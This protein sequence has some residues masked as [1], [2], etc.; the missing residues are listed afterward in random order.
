MRPNAS[1]S[2]LEHALK[3]I[4][5]ARASCG[6][7]RLAL[8]LSPTL[9][10]GDN[11]LRR[12]LNLGR[13]V[14]VYS[15]NRLLVESLPRLV[16]AGLAEGRVGCVRG[17]SWKPDDDAANPDVDR[18]AYAR[19]LLACFYRLMAFYRD[20]AIRSGYPQWGMLYRLRDFAA[21][22]TF[23]T[24]VAEY[25]SITLCRD[26]VAIARA[27]RV[28]RPRV[29]DTPAQYHAFGVLWQN[30]LRR[31]LDLDRRRNLPVRYEDILAQDRTCMEK[32]ERHLGATLDRQPFN[33]LPEVMR[34]RATSNGA[35]RKAS[36]IPPLPRAMAR[37]LVQ[38][39]EPLYSQLGY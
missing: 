8:I 32:I 13:D 10:C 36:A 25:R 6:A 9:F 18:S 21:L 23:T 16:E 5:E 15:E 26:V 29:L 28:R 39:A 35:S 27:I 12:A 3:V 37:L 11:V 30:R 20:E 34:A 22:E 4:E 19:A 33:E 14:V 24:L 31:L 7:C 17:R 2:R 1:Q 38:G